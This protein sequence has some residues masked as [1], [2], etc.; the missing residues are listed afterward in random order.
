M[1][2]VVVARSA[3]GRYT[4]ARTRTAKETARRSAFRGSLTGRRISCETALRARTRS[5]SSSSP[6][7][8][9]CDAAQPRPGGFP[10]VM[11]IGLVPYLYHPA[12]GLTSPLA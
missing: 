6:E 5:C 1:R 10:A 2:S 7:L 3:P 12:M 9:R 4:V 8:S 11:R